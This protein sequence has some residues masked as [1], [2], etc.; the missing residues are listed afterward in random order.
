[1][2]SQRIPRKPN[3]RTKL[4]PYHQAQ[5]L[6]E[7]RANPNAPYFTGKDIA[8]IYNFPTPISSP[9]VIGVV[10]VGGGL[11]G[12]VDANGVLTGGDV[13]AYWTSLGITSHPKVVIVSVDGARNTPNSDFAGTMENTIDIE[14]IGACCPG[15]NVTILFY[16]GINSFPSFFNVFKRAIQTTVN[17]NGTAIKPS[18]IS[19]S[20]GAPESRFGTLYLNSYNALFAEAKNAG[21]NICCASGDNGSSNGLPGLNVDFPSSSPNVI[22]CGGTNLICPDLTY[23]ASTIET[24]WTGSGGGFSKLFP[25]PP[26]QAKLQY[27]Q[28]AVPDIALNA[29]PNTGVIFRINNQRYN[30]GGTSIVSPAVSA[31]LAAI[32][33]TSFFLPKLYSL[34]NNVFHDIVRG[35]NGAYSATI[36]YDLCTGL[37]SFDGVVARNQ[38][39]N[40][41]PVTSIQLSAQNVQVGQQMQATATCSPSNASN[42]SVSWSSSNTSVATIN[43]NGQVNGIKIGQ[44][45]I[46]VK[47][48]DASNAAQSSFTLT[49]LPIALQSIALP[50]SISLS[51]GQKTTLTAQ[52]TPNNAANKSIIWS[53]TNPSVATVANGLVTGKSNGT[54]NIIATSVVGAKTATTTVIVST[55]ITAI[56]F[57]VGLPVGKTLTLFPTFSPPSAS[58]VQLNWTSSNASATVSQSGVVTGVSTGPVTISAVAPNGVST[59]WSLRVI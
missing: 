31:Y 1:M 48:N 35:S 32:G 24:T 34:S 7:A 21:I 13:Q 41:V 12:S 3:R 27:A 45:T 58:S 54:T 28:R 39:T 49:V 18:V 10:S 33:S 53:S 11:H 26:Y 9:I 57:S 17:V 2:S 19:C 44:A 23:T 8:N 5:P 43:A 25:S 29:D 40:W 14:T 55:P 37:G 38:L 30:V 22:A 16:I 56:S 52:F 50:S 36:G 15:S 51:I 59:S 47:A 20:W 6:I 46:T 4:R 42:K